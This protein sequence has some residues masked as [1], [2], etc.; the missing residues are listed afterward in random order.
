M[1]IYY[2]VLVIIYYK[3]GISLFLNSST[4]CLCLTK[5]WL[6]IQY[7]ENLLLFIHLQEEQQSP[8]HCPGATSL[9]SLLHVDVQSSLLTTE[10]LQ[11]HEE[12]QSAVHCPGMTSLYW[13]LHVIVQ[14]SLDIFKQEEQVQEYIHGQST[15]VPG[16]PS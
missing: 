8:L 2:L 10:H 7:F 1:S 14:E 4:I 5:F 13:L 16:S 12:Q 3:E 6:K 15:E 9:S 11:L